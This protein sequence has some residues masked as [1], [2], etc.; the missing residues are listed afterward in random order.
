MLRSKLLILSVCSDRLETKCF[1]AKGKK[2][3][4]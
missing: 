1:P 3:A 4:P 2:N